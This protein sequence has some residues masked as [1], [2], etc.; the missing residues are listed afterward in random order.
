M[1]TAFLPGIDFGPNPWH[2]VSETDPRALALV[3]GTHSLTEAP[4]YSRQH[5]GAP[6]FTGNGAS[7]V[8]VTADGLAVWSV[9]HQRVVK[10]TEWRWRCN[11]FRRV[12]GGR[13]S[14]LIRSATSATRIGWRNKYGGL[15]SV[16]LTTE[17]DPGKVRRKRDPGRCFI[18]A[19]W[20][21]IGKTKSG[22]VRLEAPAE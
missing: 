5:P 19:G 22:L 11:V 4:H 15:P 8:M 3:D 1:V 7:M 18:K 16:P 10:S 9:I 20:R 13:A 21:V 17:V 6:T 14:D 12:G 2:V